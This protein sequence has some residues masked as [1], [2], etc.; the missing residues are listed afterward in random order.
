[1]RRK[2]FPEEQIIAILKEAE[3]RGK[4]TGLGRRHDISEQTGRKPGAMKI[5]LRGLIGVIVTAMT[6]WSAGLLAFDPPVLAAEKHA[7]EHTQ[8]G[9][10]DPDAELPWAP[11][12][13]DGN[14]L[15]RVRGVPAYPAEERAKTISK[16]I[17]AIAAA[18]R[19]V[20][21][22]SLRVIESEDRTR[23]MAGD[24]K[25]QWFSAPAKADNPESK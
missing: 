19:S 10:T 11:V 17:E 4:T 24:S 18:D 1:M 15:F 3:A 12:E 22:A 2:R 25:E 21:V 5:V 14:V 6:A 13:M 23:I 7:A 8:R 20:A 9:A 16:R